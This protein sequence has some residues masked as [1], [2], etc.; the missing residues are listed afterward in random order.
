MVFSNGSHREH[1]AKGVLVGVLLTV[2]TYY[3]ANGGW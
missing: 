1:F 3:I 2:G